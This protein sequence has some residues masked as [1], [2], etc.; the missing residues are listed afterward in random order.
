MLS[1]L[2][3][4][5]SLLLGRRPFPTPAGAALGGAASASPLFPPLTPASPLAAAIAS[6]LLFL[7][8]VRH[9][10][11]GNKNGVWWQPLL[12]ALAAEKCPEVEGKGKRRKRF[13]QRVQQ[14]KW[15]HA[16]RIEG[17]RRNKIYE[18]LKKE[19]E[20]ERIRE[21]YREYGEMLRQKALKKMAETEAAAT[22]A[23]DAPPQ[24]DAQPTE[25][26]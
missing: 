9:R 20:T 3:R 15:S 6:P 10:R 7:N 23:A 13:Q 21:L 17:T 26:R 22:S 18:T 5:S 4:G 24:G 2:S 1:A 25:S 16:I 11:A 8:Q 14:S 19:R 12:P